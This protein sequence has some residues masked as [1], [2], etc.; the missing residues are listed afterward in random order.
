[1]DKKNQSRRKSNKKYYEKNKKKL[2]IKN[3]ERYL[4]IKDKLKQKRDAIK[5]D[6]NKWWTCPVCVGVT[7]LPAS[8][9]KHLSSKRHK[10]A[11]LIS[12]KVRREMEKNNNNNEWIE[13][14]DSANN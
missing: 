2:S 13:S 3:R 7:I 6:K 1:M 10:N 12:E 8:K 9:Y 4:K 5:N 11:V 14:D